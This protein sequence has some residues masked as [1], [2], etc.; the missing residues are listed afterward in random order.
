MIDL[1]AHDDEWLDNG[2]KGYPP[3]AGPVRVRD[4]G[5]RG[6]NLLAGDLPFPCAVLRESA[7]SHNGA[8]M[9]DYCAESGVVLA[10]HGKTTMAPWLFAR[11]IDDGAWGITVATMQQAN[12]CL[13]F[14]FRR[15]LMANQLVGTGDIAHLAT[16]L[17]KHPDLEFMFLVDSVAQVERIEQA[18]AGRSTGRPLTALVEVGFLNGRTGAR[19]QGEA[20]ALARRVAASPAMRLGGVECYEGLRVTPNSR[21]DTQN[22]ETLIEDVLE[23]ARACD[24]EGLFRGEEIVLS[25]GGSALFDVV[26]KVMHASL[27]RPVRTVLRS[28]CY[29]THD[30]GFYARAQAALR[31]RAGGTWATREGFRAA[32]EV[33][34]MVQSRPQRDLAILTMGKR[35]ASF[36]IDLP[37]PLHRVRRSS[38]GGIEPADRDWQVTAM[39]DQHAYLRIPTEADLA[40]G[41]LVACGI[42]HPCT[43]FDKWR[44]VWRVTDDYAVSGALRTYF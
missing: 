7:L 6:W 40:V 33:W 18:I 31:Q 23:V 21:L 22:A 17:A 39:N 41:D 1:S 11:Q 24:R 43:T 3:G 32:L 26:A 25:A 19:S 44:L 15:L 20:V 29:V 16:M 2:F 5:A 14:G 37:K 35:D 27:S 42:S 9:R 34:S 12:V 4:V 28:G 36:D 8:W 30:S 13:R 10:P 38:G